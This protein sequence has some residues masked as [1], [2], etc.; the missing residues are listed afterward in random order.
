VSYVDNVVLLMSFSERKREAGSNAIPALD[1]LN[2]WLSAREFG[3]LHLVDQYGGNKK[4]MECYV[5]I[6]AFS[7]LDYKGFMQAFRDA[8]WQD[9]DRV[10]LMFRGERDEVFKEH[11]M[12][13]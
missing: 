6:G 7:Y 1:R 9:P 2:E 12:A 11:R 5:A 10:Q 13:E 8:G 4:D 3:Q